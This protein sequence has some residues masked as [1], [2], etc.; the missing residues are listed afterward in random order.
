ML[1]INLIGK[2]NGV[3]LSRDRDLLAAAL[4]E[5]GCEVVTTSVDEA[6]AKRRRSMLAQWSVWLGQAARS[7]EQRKVGNHRFDV[8]VMLEHLWPE[9]M[10]FARFNIAV[11]NPEWFDRHD[12]SFLKLI[13]CVWAKT[14]NTLRIFRELGSAAT[15]VG[16][17]SDD[18]Y[19]P[20]VE[21]S[22]S[23]FHLA[24]KSTMKGTQRLLEVWRRHPEWPRLAVIQH[25]RTCEVKFGEATN[26]EYYTGYVGDAQLRVLQNSSHF[27]LCL[28]RTEGWGH[29][30]VE[31]L[32]VGA[33]VIAVDA[34]PMNEFVTPE[35]GLLVRAAFS[36][37]QRLADVFEFDI[38]GLE[39]AVACALAM[40]D[41]DLHAR[42]A[43][44]RYWFVRNKS[45]F[46][47]RVQ[48]AL[49]AIPLSAR[50]NSIG[51]IVSNQNP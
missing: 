12:L 21:R 25:S 9:Y 11:P 24:G 10:K 30:L 20:Q 49:D 43:A 15:W 6:G 50:G 23:F 17:D 2:D 4:R 5:C 8:N 31:A 34:P 19:D 39:K 48:R 41:D 29:Y 32:S 16:F 33:T 18:R 14:E 22:K 42:A 45:G 35:R 44:A 26:I 28:S 38:S 36:G 13:D 27:H 37:K 7:R 47:G 3:G 51:T 1:S 40:N 46:A